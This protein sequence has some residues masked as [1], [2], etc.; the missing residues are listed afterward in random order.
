MDNY[1]WLVFTV[2]NRLVRIC[3]VTDKENASAIHVVL[4]IVC[5]PL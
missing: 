2:E 4:N 3:V 1:F 5:I